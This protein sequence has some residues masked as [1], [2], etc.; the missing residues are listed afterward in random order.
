[1]ICLVGEDNICILQEIPAEE[2]QT[3]CKVREIGRYFS[4]FDK[5]SATF[6]ATARVTAEYPDL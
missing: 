4:R 6:I 5:T 3:L 1:M 2:I